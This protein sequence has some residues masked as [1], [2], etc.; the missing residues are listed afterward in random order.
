LRRENQRLERHGKK[1]DL[2]KKQM[3]KGK[4]KAAKKDANELLEGGQNV[5]RIV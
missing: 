4:I 3:R 1:N 5:G 2:K